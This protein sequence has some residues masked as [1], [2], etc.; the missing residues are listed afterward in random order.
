ML[1]GVGFCRHVPV[2]YLTIIL[3]LERKDIFVLTPFLI[4]N[5]IHF[6][7]SELKDV[8]RFWGKEKKSHCDQML[9]S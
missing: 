8:Q 3:I 4:F 9:F 5:A 7:I 2:Y 1:P 6:S